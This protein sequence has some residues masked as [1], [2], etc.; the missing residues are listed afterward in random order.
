M[1]G[2]CLVTKSF[3]LSVP[4]PFVT[5]HRDIDRELQEVVEILS[6]G[7]DSPDNIQDKVLKERERQNVKKAQESFLQLLCRERYD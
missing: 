2:Q 5:K 6:P 4:L 1:L 3:V 7:P